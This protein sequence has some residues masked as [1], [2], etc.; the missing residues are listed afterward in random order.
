MGTY[1][2]LFF[3]YSGVLWDLEH[4]IGVAVGLL[5]GPLLVGRRR[6]AAAAGDEPRVAQ[7]R[8]PHV[9]RVGRRPPDALVFPADGP[10]G[11]TSDDD[12]AWGALV[13][14]AI[15]LLLANGLRKGKRISWRWAI[16]ITSLFLG[17]LLLGSVAVLVD[18]V[19]NDLDL[20]DAGLPAIVVDLLLWVVQ[21]VVLLLGR[22]AFRSPSARKLRKPVPW[23]A[24]SGRT[25]CSCC[26][27]TAARRCPG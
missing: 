4:L 17:L 12:S 5:V 8:R 23:T 11:A 15:S 24:T 7:H 1:A 3:L 6:A 9:R 14:A 2:V 27:A 16:A 13:T 10:L 18:P 19:E 22:D 21:F 20:G 25:P 26:S